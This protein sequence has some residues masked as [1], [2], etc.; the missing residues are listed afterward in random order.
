M[1]I[2]YDDNLVCDTYM[3]VL[4]SAKHWHR[5]LALLMPFVLHILI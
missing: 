4:N 5:K 3:K 2:I 1:L